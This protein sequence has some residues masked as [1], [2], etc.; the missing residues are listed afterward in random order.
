MVDGRANGGVALANAGTLASDAQGRLSWAFAGDTAGPA[1]DV[2]TGG[3]F[4]LESGTLTRHGITVV[5]RGATAPVLNAS[6]A[7]QTAGTPVINDYNLTGF[8]AYIAGMLGD[9]FSSYEACAI[10]GA[11]TGDILKFLPQ[12]FQL[13]TEVAVITAGVNDL[14]TTSAACVATIANLKSIIDFAASKARFVYVNEIFPDILATPAIVRNLALVS[15]AIKKYCATK[16]NVRFV[17][18]FDKLIAPNAYVIGSGAGGRPGAYQADNLHLKP[19]GAYWAG[20]GIADAIAKDYA[21][22]PGDRGTVATWDSTLQLG[23]LNLNPTLRGTAGA[24]PGTGITGT[25]PDSWSLNRA[26]STQ[27]CTTAFVAA[28][29]G[30]IDFWTMDVS[31]A[32]AGDY[33][34]LSQSVPLPAGVAVGDYVQFACETVV[35]TTSGAGLNIF[36]VYAVTNG[37]LQSAYL[38]QTSQNVANFTTEAPVLHHRSEP[39]EILPGVTSF[40]MRVRAGAAGA[41]AGTGKVGIRKFRFEKCAAPVYA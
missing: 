3:W 22:E 20:K 34:E 6:S 37:N 8:A 9:T 24:V 26:G 21:I 29:D 15:E 1:V 18:S 30:G 10:A 12:A 27:L 31:G 5:V 41:S 4:Y 25:A 2:S 19:F 40:A 17:S 13:G 32:T 14:P 33:N 28:A 11:T 38:L 39:M 23:S 16:K 7:V 35:L 36:N